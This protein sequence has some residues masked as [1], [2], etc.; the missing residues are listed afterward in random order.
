MRSFFGLL[1]ILLTIYVGTQFVPVYV[2]NF[3]LEESIDDTAQ[4][5]SRPFPPTEDEARKWVL[6]EARA[7][8]I[9]L[10]PE[11]V[12]VH[13]RYTEGVIWA[14]YTVHVT[15]LSHPVDLHFQPASHNR[16]MVQG[17]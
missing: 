11:Q 16:R 14:D 9:D 12:V 8:D 17:F 3:R 6:A 7:L 2:A 4:A 1:L 15:L 13:R 5:F 10:N